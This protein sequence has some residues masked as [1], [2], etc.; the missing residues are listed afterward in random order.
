MQRASTGCGG[1]GRLIA[2]GD[3]HPSSCAFRVA[4]GR[5]TP[6]PARHGADGLR[7]LPGG[8]RPRNYGNRPCRSRRTP[9]LAGG[10]QA[11][12]GLLGAVAGDSR[13][14]NPCARCS[15]INAN[16]LEDAAGRV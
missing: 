6:A 16:R 7:P 13:I 11:G 5:L 3:M 1:S 2:N 9:H 14:S 12:A 15:A 10:L 4:D 8:E